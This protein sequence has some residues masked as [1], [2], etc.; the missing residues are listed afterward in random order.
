MEEPAMPVGPII[1][2]DDARLE[3]EFESYE[4]AVAVVVEPVSTPKFLANREK[5]REICKIMISV[6]PENL[7]IDAG[8][9]R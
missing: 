9:G 7:N 6:A 5:N 1:N 3:P 4:L 2:C 8:T